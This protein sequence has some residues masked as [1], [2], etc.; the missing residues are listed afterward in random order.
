MNSLV[1][2]GWA[3]CGKQ[4]PTRMFYRPE[5]VPGFGLNLLIV[6]VSLI[7]LMRFGGYRWACAHPP[8][9]LLTHRVLICNI[10]ALT[11]LSV[12]ESLRVYLSV[13]VDEEFLRQ[14]LADYGVCDPTMC[15]TIAIV[16]C[17]L[18]NLII[19]PR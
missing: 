14:R 2:P 18:H 1:T 9:D 7:E 5:Q 13:S 16:R 8:L 17:Q 15:S 4:K 12:Y 3:P 6:Y 19:V 11:V 10:I